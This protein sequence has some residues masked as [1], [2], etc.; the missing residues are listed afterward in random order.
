MLLKQ[1]GLYICLSALTH[2]S[3]RGGFGILGGGRNPPLGTFAEYVVVE[4]NQVVRS[5][6]HLDDVQVSAWPLGGLTAWRLVF[7]AIS[8]SSYH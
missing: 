7:V 8:F 5:P 2:F 1:S 3:Y 6:D 4:R